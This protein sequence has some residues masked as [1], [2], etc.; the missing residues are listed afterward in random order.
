M[1]LKGPRPLP[2]LLFPSNSGPSGVREVVF[3]FGPYVGLA[4]RHEN[5]RI[6]EV[7]WSR[8]ALPEGVAI[9]IR[10]WYETS[11]HALSFLDGFTSL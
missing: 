7:R 5:R 1:G 6:V 9:T 3:V 2:R 4:E 8:W 11:Y 10:A